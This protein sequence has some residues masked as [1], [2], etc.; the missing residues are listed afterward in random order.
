MTRFRKV[1]SLFALVVLSVAASSQSGSPSTEREGAVS[2]AV[3]PAQ[4]ALPSGSPQPPDLCHGVVVLDH[5]GEAWVKL[6]DGLNSRVADFRCQLTPIGKPAPNLHVV[7]EVEGNGFHIAGG[8]MKQK[9]S[10]QV[11]G[12]RQSANTHAS[13]HG[14]AGPAEND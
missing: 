9:V 14:T 8:R 12:S 5:T 10:W 2:C 3:I 6:P 7:N 4:S 1:F 11:I 13:S